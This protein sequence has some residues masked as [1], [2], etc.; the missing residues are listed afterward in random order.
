MDRHYPGMKTDKR[1]LML[2]L[3]AM[4]S[5]RLRGS[6]RFRGGFEGDA[7]SIVRV[8]CVSCYPVDEDRLR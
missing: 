1:P 3:M 2:S 5:F 8:A 7:E 6:E 4:E